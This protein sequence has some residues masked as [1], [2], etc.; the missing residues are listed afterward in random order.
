M[1]GARLESIVTYTERAFFSGKWSTVGFMM[2][3]RGHPDGIF[4]GKKTATEV[5]A[6]FND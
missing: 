3:F 5:K 4:F 2:T 6:A 1:R